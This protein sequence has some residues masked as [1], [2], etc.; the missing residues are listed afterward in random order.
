MAPFEMTVNQNNPA[1]DCMSVE[2]II[3]SMINPVGIECEYE[4]LLIHQTG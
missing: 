4:L 2:N 1:R 3:L